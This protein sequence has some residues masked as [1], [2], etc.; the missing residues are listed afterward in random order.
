MDNEHIPLF[1]KTAAH[2]ITIAIACSASVHSNT[3]SGTPYAAPDIQIAA[4]T[5]TAAAVNT[6]LASYLRTAQTTSQWFKDE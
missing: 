5:T 6:G 4:V 2:R 3:S 1:S